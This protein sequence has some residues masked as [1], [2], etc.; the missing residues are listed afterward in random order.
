MDSERV[1]TSSS[2]PALLLGD[3]E[4]LRCQLGALDPGSDL[5][6]GGLPAGRRTV[7]EGGEAAVVTGAKPVDRDI[8]SRLEDT[9]SDLLWSLDPG[10]DR[11]DDS[12]EDPAVGW[13]MF[14]DDA[15]DSRPVGLA[16]K[17]DVEGP[18]LQLE[19]HGEQFG[20]VHVQA[21]RRIH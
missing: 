15:E 16:R 13:G 10:V 17:L 1:P 20:V 2:I 12:D 4:L 8:F 19:Q 7:A 6:E 21:V 11:V 5:G 9:V 18:G 14:L 3:S